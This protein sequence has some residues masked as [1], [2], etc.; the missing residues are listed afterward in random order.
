[1]HKA[2]FS[3]RKAFCVFVDHSNNRFSSVSLV[4]GLAISAN[5]EMNRL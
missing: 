3:A 2:S 1:M 5:P 4:S